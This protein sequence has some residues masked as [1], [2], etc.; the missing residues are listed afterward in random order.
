MQQQDTP[1]F[2]PFLCTQK[3]IYFYEFVICWPGLAPFASAAGIDFSK[4]FSADEPAPAA[5]PVKNEEES[6]SRDS[7]DEEKAAKKKRA[8]KSKKHKR[9]RS[10]KHSRRERASHSSSDDEMTVSVPGLFEIDTTPDLSSMRFAAWALMQC[11]PLFIAFPAVSAQFLM[12]HCT[13]VRA[14]V[15]RS[16]TC[17]A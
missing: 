2:G 16:G 12:H 4:L 8:K 17:L 1:A 13:K 9:E 5:D 15:C 10:S 3:G 14:P 11:S 7:S 6:S